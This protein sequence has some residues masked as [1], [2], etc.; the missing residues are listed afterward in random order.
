[1]EQ[2]FDLY[3]TITNNIIEQLKKGTIPWHKPWHTGDNLGAFSRVTKRPYSLLN[4]MCLKHIGEYATFDQWQKLGGKV[5]KGEHSEIVVFW[6]VNQKKNPNFKGYVEVDGKLTAIDG[7]KEFNNYPLLRYYRVFHISQVEGVD[8]LPSDELVF[9][10]PTID[11]I[12]EVIKAYADETAL[13]IQNNDKSGAYYSPMKDLV[14][15]PPI[16]NFE[17]TDEYYSTMFHELT[18]ST[19]SVKRLN[20]DTFGTVTFF[21]SQDYSKEELVAELGSQFICNKLGIST[22]Q[23]FQNSSAYIKSW[24][25]VLQNDTKMIVSASSK[26]QK[27]CEYLLGFSEEETEEVEETSPAEKPKIILK[28]LSQLKKFV[29]IGKKFEILWHWKGGNV[30]TIREITKACATKFISTPIG[31]N[32]EINCWYDKAQNWRFEDDIITM[33]NSAGNEIMK[34]RFI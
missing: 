8:P 33:L 34:F 9:E 11:R 18:H 23:T 12:E 31:E 32:K 5:K 30:G 17:N 14:N 3:E 15:V 13:T 6:K 10:T 26:A 1:M 2:K 4:Q 20:R 7:E 28:N 24:I 21:G 29:E 25:K 27:A 16:E 22:E 19:G